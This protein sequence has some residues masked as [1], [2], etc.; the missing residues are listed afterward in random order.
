MTTKRKRANFI[1]THM[2]SPD[3][4]LSPFTRKFFDTCF[5]SQS[6]IDPTPFFCST[7]YTLLWA[8]LLDAISPTRAFG[9]L[10]Q[11]VPPYNVKS[12]NNVQYRN[13]FQDSCSILT[14]LATHIHTHHSNDIKQAMKSE[15]RTEL[16]TPIVP[17]EMW[18]PL[19]DMAPEYAVEQFGYAS[20]YIERFLMETHLYL[21]KVLNKMD[22]T[23]ARD[24][25]ITDLLH[26]QVLRDFLGADFMFFL[27]C[28]FG[29][30]YGLNLRNLAWHG[31]LSR[32]EWYEPYNTLLLLTVWS[33][34]KHAAKFTPSPALVK[35]GIPD[36]TLQEL[37]TLCRTGALPSRLA[38][39][40]GVLPTTPCPIDEEHFKNPT[41]FLGHKS[42]AWHRPGALA[43]VE[44]RGYSH[45]GGPFLDEKKWI[46]EME[47]EFVP[48]RAMLAP[49]LEEVFRDEALIV[50]LL[51][52]SDF[53]PSHFHNQ[54]LN[55]CAAF[56][57]QRYLEAAA[58]IVILLEVCLRWCFGKWNNIDYMYRSPNGDGLLTTIDVILDPVL[59]DTDPLQ[60]HITPPPETEAKPN[61]LIEHFP[62]GVVALLFD[63]YIWKDGPR[64]RDDL[65]HAAVNPLTVPWDCVAPLMSVAIACLTKVHSSSCNNSS[66][67]DYP[68][69]NTIVSWVES[70][71]PMV[72]PEVLLRREIQDCYTEDLGKFNALLQLIH[73]RPMFPGQEEPNAQVIMLNARPPDDP[74]FLL[75]P[76]VYLD[77]ARKVA[78]RNLKVHN[79]NPIMVP[80]SAYV[81][82]AT[83]IPSDGNIQALAMGVTSPLSF[84]KTPQFRGRITMC[85]SKYF[86]KLMILRR[87]VSFVSVFFSTMTEKYQVVY[88]K[89]MARTLY[90]KP[91]QQYARYVGDLP[92]LS[93]LL[94]MITVAVE[95]IFTETTENHE[96]LRCQVLKT[97]ECLLACLQDN[98]WFRSNAEV[99]TLMAMMGDAA[100]GIPIAPLYQ[101]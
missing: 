49:A 36:F 20:S 38:T 71:R 40:S 88:E 2:F 56:R 87:I 66:D 57:Q 21:C 5:L 55:T 47:L 72:A 99:Q 73:S 35:K 16:N 10:P 9:G 68:A 34:P 27:Q 95:I 63:H 94:V 92:S 15:I 13:H 100:E 82:D 19:I 41:A 67:V 75:S 46:D 60:P 4:C 98:Q 1:N 37:V 54:F 65:A 91:R 79:Q 97:L 101:A 76:D 90:K 32:E 83:L 24:L 17:P 18:V 69:V 51:K 22:S 3:T 29:P 25:R 12:A 58:G 11:N 33:I 6:K 8:P 86:V 70:Y 39:F 48:N 44:W 93:A 84:T 96:G 31:F 81:V 61:K 80:F 85:I 45:L 64:L 42:P 26:Q 53:V 50:G 89:A 30:L 28:L 59:D 14:S 78:H 43:M 74:N 7:S 52:R 77:V 23:K 62:D